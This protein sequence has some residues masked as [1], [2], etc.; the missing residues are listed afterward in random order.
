MARF[1]RPFNQV[2][3]SPGREL[4]AYAARN[5]AEASVPLSF[6]VFEPV[7][8]GEAPSQDLSAYLEILRRR[9]WQILVP[10]LILF[11]LSLLVALR[12]P[13]VY[14][15]TATILIE[16]PETPADLVRSTVTS[17]A[18]Q[19][20]QVISQQIMTRANLWQIIEKHDLYA[21]KRNQAPSE[22]ILN[23][24]RKRIKLDLVSSDVV[25]KRSGI[26]TSATIAFTLSFDGETPEQA[27]R[28]ANEL[29]SLYLSENLKSR[30]QKAADTSALLTD[31][32][33]KHGER[34]AVLEEKIAGFKEKNIGRLPEFQQ[35]N[36]QLRDRTEMEM[37]E[38][39][40]QMRAL[41][42]RKFYLEGQLAQVKPNTPTI[43]A[44]G[45]KVLDREERLKVLQAQYTAASAS[46][47]A[48]HP[49][50]V[51]LRREI[52]ALERQIGG[53]SAG[54]EQAKRLEKV[55]LDLAA[56]REKYSEDHP[57]VVRLTREQAAL[58]KSIQ[59]ASRPERQVHARAPEN[60]A[61]IAL[62]TQREVTNTEVKALRAKQAELRSRLI[63]L[64]TRLQQTP[65]VEREYQ[66]L[67]RERES[68]VRR[69][70]EIKAKQAEAQ[71]A[72]ELE[73]ESKG[74]R[75]SLIDPPQLP[76]KPD[77][78]KRKAIVLLGFLLSLGGGVGYGAL[79][80]T[81][82]RSIRGPT[83]LAA[84]V[85]VPLLAAIPY[86]ENRGDLKRRRRARGVVA[87]SAIGGILALAMLFHML[88]MPVDEAWSA[89][90]R[91]VGV[92]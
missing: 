19:R 31:E 75:F 42:E 34:I 5:S 48:E 9:K 35:L 76:E 8:G 87:L 63:E 13:P 7:A 15:S 60:P 65:Q 64:E 85:D 54:V 56:A 86:I 23:A 55:R 36:L 78:P 21:D 69:Y 79:R 62:Q 68:E 66:D 39:E 22:G 24:V 12:L 33:K 73:K 57:D 10:A 27:Q 38:A 82:D 70:Q 45:E 80:E 74:E 67:Q 50:V 28:V 43:T 52:E 53:T 6:P 1:L 89:L 30:Q 72:Q 37:V 91:Q 20:I 4:R 17:Y 26:K 49:D 88:V 61:Y 51:K 77:R 58:E 84:A 47:S 16:D 90:L 41:E 44:S 11:L 32:A 83:G 25:D 92:Y 14:R 40:R 71:V 18:D 59:S 81:L 2:R 46:Y 29:V 3:A